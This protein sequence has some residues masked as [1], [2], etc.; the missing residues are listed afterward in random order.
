MSFFTQ[1]TKALNA[2]V[3]NLLA[4]QFDTPTPLPVIFPLLHILIGV[5]GLAIINT[6]FIADVPDNANYVF[7][8]FHTATA[9]IGGWLAMS[10]PVGVG[11]AQ[12]MIGTTYF[13]FLSINAVA[14][15]VFAAQTS[16]IVHGLYNALDLGFFVLAIVWIT[17][18]PPRLRND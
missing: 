12:Y 7:L 2:S 5:A 1:T 4:P 14:T 18:L 10:S 9:I 13:G 3:D 8:G 6:G 17:K 15:I 16:Q 11:K